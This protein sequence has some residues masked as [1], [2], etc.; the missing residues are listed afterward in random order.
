MEMLKNWLNQIR[1]KSDHYGTAYWNYQI[2]GQITEMR[3]NP[4]VIYN[5]EKFKYSVIRIGMAIT[6]LSHRLDK[7]NI[8]FHIQTFPV[9]E[10]LRIVAAIRLNLNQDFLN[11]NAPQKKPEPTP[12]SLSELAADIAKKFQFQLLA[13][14]PHS[15]TAQSVEN[16]NPEQTWHLLCSN[17]NNPFTWLNIGYLG[18]NLQMKN[19]DQDAAPI[20]FIINSSQLEKIKQ[21][22]TEPDPVKF[23]HA[24][25]AF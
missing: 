16:Q 17:Q 12:S 23:A 15:F 21:M 4:D 14:S 2:S 11:K 6:Q 9:L 25:I 19:R 24:L 8:S 10:D 18:E 1:A 5:E 3:V 7:E 13:L 22:K 20:E